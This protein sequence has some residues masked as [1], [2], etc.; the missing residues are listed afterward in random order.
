M[1]LYKL[2]PGNARLFKNIGYMRLTFA[3]FKHLGAAYRTFALGC[4][5]AIFHGYNPGI[6]HLPFSPALHTITLHLFPPARELH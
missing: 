4:R 3:D 2:N 6:F 1:G 5:P